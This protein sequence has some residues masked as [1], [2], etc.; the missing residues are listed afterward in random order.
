MAWTSEAFLAGTKTVTRLFWKDRYAAQF[1]A[2]E[3]CQV[4]DKNPRAGG[5][6]IGLLRITRTPYRECI[7][8]ITE[9]HFRREG[10]T[11]YWRGREECIE[12]M[13]GILCAPWVIEFERVNDGS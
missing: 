12:A 1:K 7:D 13:G 11:R 8:E 6:R 4:Y 2:G 10:G 9:E 5:K 3:I